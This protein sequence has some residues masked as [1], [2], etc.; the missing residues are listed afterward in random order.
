[1]LYSKD[2]TVSMCHFSL[3]FLI[4]IGCIC[5][6]FLHCAFLNVSSNGLPEKRHS[7]MVAF[8]WLFSTVCFQMCPQITCLR[9]GKVTL[10][11]FAWLFSTVHIQ[12]SPEI[13]FLRRGIVTLVAFA[14]LFSTVYF[15]MFHQMAWQIRWKVT[16]VAFAWLFSTVHYDARREIK[17]IKSF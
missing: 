5:L 8:A 14:W 13:A 2:L 7:L 15:Q 12:M 4:H 6:T 1:M 16:L 10:V 3:T 9:R 11:A 17:E